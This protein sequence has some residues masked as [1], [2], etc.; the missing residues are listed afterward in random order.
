M[1]ACHIYVNMLQMEGF[2]YCYLVKL[3]SVKIIIKTSTREQKKNLF[4]F[5]ISS[6]L[7]MMVMNLLWPFT[8]ITNECVTHAAGATNLKNQFVFSMIWQ[9]IHRA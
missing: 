5:Q 6:N 2:Y 1:T 7:K 3:F 8:C 4:G 9:K